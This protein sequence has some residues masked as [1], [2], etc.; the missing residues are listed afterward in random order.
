MSFRTALRAVKPFRLTSLIFTYALGGGLVQYVE[1]MRSWSSFIQGGIFLILLALSLDL[2]GVLN[3][4]VDQ[5]KWPEGMTLE[6]ARGTRIIA[7]LSAATFLTVGTTILIGWMVGGLFWQGLGFLIGA[8]VLVGVFYY[9]TLIVDS[10]RVYQIFVE[11]VFFV[12]IPPAL[13]FFLQATEPHRLLT[14]AV[15]GL[16]PAYIAYRLLVQLKHFSHDQRSGRKTITAEVGWEK[17]MVFHN[18]SILVTYFLMALCAILGFPWFLLWPVFLSLPI[19]LLE[20]WLM[21]RTRRGNKPL[22]SVMQFAS[23]S[24]FFIPLYLL[25]FAFWIR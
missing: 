24:V 17:A 1:Q 16:A 11:A 13:A 21:E 7:G 19:G 9:L 6:I 22:W 23:A 25:G 2:L 10:L 3:E 12:I 8:V 14:M 15:I 4:L 20:I 5:Q 18:A